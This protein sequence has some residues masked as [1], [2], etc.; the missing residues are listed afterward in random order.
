M[1]K[2]S[3]TMKLN[4]NKGRSWH[5]QVDHTAETPSG[6]YLVRSNSFNHHYTCLFRPLGG[7]EAIDVGWDEP[8]NLRQAK[9][10]CQA[11]V[12]MGS[13]LTFEKDDLFKRLEK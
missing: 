3:P 5:G 2:L 6:S 12:D 4:W 9:K 13:P 1:V 10:Q 8:Y 11:H 7:G